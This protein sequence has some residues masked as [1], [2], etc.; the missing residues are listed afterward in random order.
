[1]NYPGQYVLGY[2]QAFIEAGA[3]DTDK[4]AMERLVKQARHLVNRPRPSLEMRLYLALTGFVATGIALIY[5][6]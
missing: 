2:C 5:Q 4:L 3:T 6:W 1:M